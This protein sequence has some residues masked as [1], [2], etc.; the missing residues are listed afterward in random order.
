MNVHRVD[1]RN[2]EGVTPKTVRCICGAIV[3]IYEGPK[4]YTVLSDRVT[5]PG[6]ASVPRGD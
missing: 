3:P 5:C 4:Q 2:Q 1:V 6:C